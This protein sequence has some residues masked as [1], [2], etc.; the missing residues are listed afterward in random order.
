MA[1]LFNY[2]EQHQDL[3]FYDQAP[4]DIDFLILTELCY[5]PYN[6]LLTDQSDLATSMRLSDLAVAYFQK[7]GKTPLSSIV[8]KDRLQ[9]LERVSTSKRFKNIKAFAFVDDYNLD[10]Q[11]QFSAMTYRLMT[12]HFLVSFRG[13]D[14]SLIGWKEDFHMTY[15]TE[16]PSQ[17]AAQAYLTKLLTELEGDFHLAGHSKGGNLALFAASHLTPELQD[18]VGT[19]TTY[20]APGLHRSLISSPGYRQIKPCIRAY[21]PQ[22]SV[23]GLMLEVPKQVQVVKSNSLGLLQHLTFS[24]Q[25]EDSHF[26]LIDQVTRRSQQTDRALTAWNEE[27]SDQE[28]RDFFDSFFGIFLDAG[29]ERLTDLDHDRP[30]KIQA[31]VQSAQ[32]LPTKNKDLI[33]RL[34]KQLFQTH[35]QIIRDDFSPPSWTD[36]EHFF[37]KK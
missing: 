36:V 3:S 1:N 17:I 27:L 4:N 12:G 5:L 33:Q 14:D 11:K 34:I 31:I 20:D 8:N 21:I 22:D 13:T 16:I 10:Q 32:Q 25:I 15:M 6:D 26:V 9:L 37:K 23:V 29:I 2:L 28:L 24:W 30:K 35:F 18:K 7:Y 19:I